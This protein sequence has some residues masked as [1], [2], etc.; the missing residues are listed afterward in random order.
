M[1]IEERQIALGQKLEGDNLEYAFL[2][3][4]EVSNIS[5]SILMIKNFASSSKKPKTKIAFSLTDYY[6][7]QDSLLNKCWIPHP[8]KKIDYINGVKPSFHTNYGEFTW[9]GMTFYPYSIKTDLYKLNIL[10]ICT[11]L[12]GH[13]NFNAVTD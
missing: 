8:D 7:G 2:L 4:S 3:G 1:S 10:K 5:D 12:Y 11:D 13:I 6:K 9:D